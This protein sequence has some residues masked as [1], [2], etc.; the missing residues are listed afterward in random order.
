MISLLTNFSILTCF[1][2]QFPIYDSAPACMIDLWSQPSAEHCFGNPANAT[3]TFA[4]RLTQKIASFY[5][6]TIDNPGIAE[7][8]GRINNS[9]T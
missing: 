9:S 6:I 7:L 2:K 4:P 8:Y 3:G 5:V 1:R